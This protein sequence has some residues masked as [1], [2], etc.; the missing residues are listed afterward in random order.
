MSQVLKQYQRLFSITI[1]VFNG[2]AIPGH[3][4]GKRD[5]QVDK[6]R[7]WMREPETPSDSAM[8]LGDL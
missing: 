5:H 6:V 8:E 2:M 7:A 4:E 1:L 3:R